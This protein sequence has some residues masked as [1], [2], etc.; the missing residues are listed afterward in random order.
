MDRA[1]ND[2]AIVTASPSVND[3]RV[4]QYDSNVIRIFFDPGH[5][6]VMEN[7]GEFAASVRREGGDPNVTV[8]VDFRTE[9]GSANAGSDYIAVAG[10]LTFHPRE[11]LKTFNVCV[12]DDD[13][14][15]EDEH[16][17]IRLSNARLVAS[18]ETGYGNTSSIYAFKC[19]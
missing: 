14:F 12:I 13:V 18:T 11:T 8:Q 9:D 4:G 3:G 16:F 6:T 15:E 5:Y 19:D 17:Y 7:V 1:A 10:T 2:A